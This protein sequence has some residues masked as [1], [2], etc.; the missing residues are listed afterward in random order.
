MTSSGDRENSRQVLESPMTVT[1]A[2]RQQSKFCEKPEVWA[3][4]VVI[5]GICVPGRGMGD[6]GHRRHTGVGTESKIDD[7]VCP[8]GGRRSCPSPDPVDTVAG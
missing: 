4:A 1:A 7:I 6:R 3:M 5:S 2:G 8:H